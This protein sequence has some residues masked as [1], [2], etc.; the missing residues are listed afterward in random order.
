MYG[1]P[2]SNGPDG[3]VDFTLTAA[4]PPVLSSELLGF[5]PD[6]RVLIINADDFGMYRSVNVAIIK[7]M[8]EGLASS[9]S[10]MV[11][12]PW[13]RHA[14]ELLRQR[15]HIQFGIHLTLVCDFTGYRW[16]PVAA[17]E[18]VPSLL[19]DAGQLFTP[20]AKA[21]LLQQARLD[22]IEL[23]LRSQ[24]D[25]VMGAG[26]APTHLDWHCL[27]DGGR[28]D[29][30]DLSLDLAEEYGLAARVWLGPGRRT[31]RQR[32]LP[33]VDH[34]FLDSF[35]LDINTKA[36]RYAEL[37][38]DL[39]TGLNEWAVHPGL[40]DE[41]STAIDSGWRV[42]R[43][44]LEFLTSPEASEI[45]RQENIAVIDYRTVQRAWSHQQ[46]TATG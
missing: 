4:A 10:L 20:D 33:V 22:E 6:A 38:H 13:A 5:P 16:A 30:F 9:C 15:P 28:D 39:P 23:E 18:L 37:L 41:E 46:S 44:D 42:R 17:K 43:G 11:P 26:L 3:P 14:M 1:W 27:A 21:Q 34:D 2:S 19:D 24:I 7:S 25:V 31:A 12:C 45:V 29:I 32:G 40:G 36:A 8:E 35:A